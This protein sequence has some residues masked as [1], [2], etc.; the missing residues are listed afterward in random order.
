MSEG[1][2]DTFHLRLKSLLDVVSNL[3]SYYLFIY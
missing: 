3:K 1:E 2:R